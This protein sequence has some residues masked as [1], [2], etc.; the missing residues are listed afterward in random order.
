MDNRSE[1]QHFLRGDVRAPVSN[2]SNRIIAREATGVET[3]EYSGRTTLA[4]GV[5]DR[6]CQKNTQKAPLEQVSSVRGLFNV[7]EF[8]N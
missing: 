2:V 1:Q 6:H 3:R 5:R 8:L 7:M 4:P